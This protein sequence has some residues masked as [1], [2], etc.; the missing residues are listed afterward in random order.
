MH[1]RF[2][3]VNH[4]PG[5]QKGREK[6]AEERRCTKSQTETEMGSVSEREG[7][8]EERGEG[9]RTGGDVRQT[10]AGIRG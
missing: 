3:D 4:P 1:F 2:D 5:G 9:E 7:T 10:D 6:E 8:K